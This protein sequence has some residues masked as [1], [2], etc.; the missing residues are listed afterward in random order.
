M[1]RFSTLL[2][3]AC[4]KKQEIFL[5]GLLTSVAGM[6]RFG[7]ILCVLASLREKKIKN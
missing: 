6:A 7:N 1:A 3:Q 5:S 2:P 4:H